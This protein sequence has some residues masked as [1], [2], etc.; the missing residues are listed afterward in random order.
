MIFTILESFRD[1]ASSFS[2]L[3]Q[4]LTCILVRQLWQCRPPAVALRSGKCGNLVRHVWFA[5]G[6]CGGR[7][8]QAPV[9]VSKEGVRQVWLACT[10]QS[11]P[12]T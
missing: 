10:R 3:N 12:S 11:I 1:F 2:M 9:S 5:S 6:M 7:Y 4:G 8:P